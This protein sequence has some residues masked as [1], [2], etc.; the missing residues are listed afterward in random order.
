MGRLTIG[1]ESAYGAT[2]MRLALGWVTKKSGKTRM[3]KEIE[4]RPDM[5]SGEKWS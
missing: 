4:N 2:R 5:N 1:G 3:N